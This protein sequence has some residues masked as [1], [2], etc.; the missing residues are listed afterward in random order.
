MKLG[1][2]CIYPKLVG[3]YCRVCLPGYKLVRLGSS[4][5]GLAV[6]PEIKEEVPAMCVLE[7]SKV[8][9]FQYDSKK[10]GFSPCLVEDC[11]ECT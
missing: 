10:K 1:K 8:K 3:S 7:N 5:L 4:K 6:Y 11:E 2:I 9:G